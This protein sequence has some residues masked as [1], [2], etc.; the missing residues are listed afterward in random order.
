MSSCRSRQCWWLHRL[1]FP[2][3]TPQSRMCNYEGCPNSKETHTQKCSRCSLA[4][5]CGPGCQR[6]DWARHKVWCSAA[7]AARQCDR[8]REFPG[9]VTPVHGDKLITRLAWQQFSPALPGGYI[10]VYHAPFSIVALGIIVKM[11]PPGTPGPVA[12]GLDTVFIRGE[13]VYLGMWGEDFSERS[14]RLIFTKWEEPSC[15]ICRQA[16]SRYQVSCGECKT[17]F[18][19][20]CMQN[21]HNM[22]AKGGTKCPVCRHDGWMPVP[23]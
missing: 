10:P 22:G 1:R 8:C 19:L 21:M 23:T 18:C 9:S 4:E 2:V 17:S 14:L 5:Y 16:P 3:G 12:A 20:S 13:D 6:A 15:C 7:K 11:Q